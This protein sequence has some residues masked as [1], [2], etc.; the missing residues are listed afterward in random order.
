M[1]IVVKTLF[2]LETLLLEEI[3]AL[4]MKGGKALNRAVE[5]EGDWKEVYT[6]NYRCR[7]AISVLV[8]IADFSI[9]N[10]DDLYKKAIEIDWPSYFNRDKTFAVKGAVFSEMFKHTQFPFLLVKDAIADRFRKQ[11][12]DRPDVNVKSPQVLFDVHIAANKVTISLNTSGLPLYQRGY[13]SMTGE[14]P[15]NE[16]LA[17]GLIK[18]AGWDQK[19]TFIDPMCGSGTIVIEAALMAANIPAMVE[20]EHYAFKNFSAYDSQLWESVKASVNTKPIKLDFDI[21]GSDVDASVLQKAKR[22]AR[23]APIGNMIKF[24]LHDISE[25]KKSTERGTLICNPPYGERIGDDVQI[26]YETM[27]NVFKKG[28]VGYDCWIIS[29]NEEALKCVGL[30][31]ASK[32]KVFNGNLA[33]SFRKYVVYEGSKKNRVDISTET[34]SNHQNQIVPKSINTILQ[35]EKPLQISSKTGSKYKVRKVNSDNKE[36]QVFDQSKS[37]SNNRTSHSANKESTN[38]KERTNDLDS[39]T[40][41]IN[42]FRKGRGK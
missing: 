38:S 15:I 39:Y 3:E 30:K 6:L 42:Q 20:R 5:L 33:C 25:L 28:L 34:M 24:Q 7:L 32:V 8:R 41:K 40:A 9:K 1:K 12:G 16:V 13:R 18:L 26:L 17:A 21:I 19:S 29:S 36:K 22:N 27:G 37:K 10:E 14:A 23:S 11:T 35:E 2:G 31:P 4:G